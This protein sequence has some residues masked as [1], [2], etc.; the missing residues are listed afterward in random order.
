LRRFRGERRTSVRGL[1]DPKHSRPPLPA[2]VVRSGATAC[3]RGRKACEDGGSRFSCP[4][5]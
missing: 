2:I 4:F 5:D 1:Q 3:E